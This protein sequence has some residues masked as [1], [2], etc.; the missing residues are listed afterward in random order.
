M[1]SWERKAHEVITQLCEASARQANTDPRTGRL[2]QRHRPYSV[3]VIAQ[4]LVE[5]LSHRR[6]DAEERAKALF[7]QLNEI[8][9]CGEDAS[10][11]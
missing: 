7:L 8:P 11:A 5:C 10:Y 4:A 2:Y 3:P 1:E 9:E 6:A